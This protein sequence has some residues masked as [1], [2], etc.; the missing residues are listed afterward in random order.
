MTQTHLASLVATYR[1]SGRTVTQCPTLHAI[2]SRLRWRRP[3]PRT[4]SL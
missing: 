4:V 3:L 2:G 1:A